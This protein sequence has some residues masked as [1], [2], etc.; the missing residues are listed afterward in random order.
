MKRITNGG[1]AFI[2]LFAVFVGMTMNPNT[3]AASRSQPPKSAEAA[4]L[5][6]PD[7]GDKLFVRIGDEEE[8]IH[9][10]GVDAPEVS[11]WECLA[12]E[13]G[14]RVIELAPTDTE[15]YIERGQTER[16]KGGRLYAYI[17]IPL[18][19]RWE[20]L[21]QV[22]LR[23]GLAGYDEP[24]AGNTKYDKELKK[25]AGAAKKAKDGYF[26]A[27]GSKL[28]NDDKKYRCLPVSDE[29]VA[30]I[31]ALSYD[32]AWAGDLLRGARAV[33][34]PSYVHAYAVAADIEGPGMEGNDQVAVWFV[35]G[36]V[37]SADY[38]LQ[39]RGTQGFA[40]QYTPSIDAFGYV[41][42][43]DFKG[44]EEARGCVQDA[45]K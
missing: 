19:G 10:I 7:D 37:D 20:L 11:K 17:W 45:T 27:C 12:F 21:N 1:F 14:D 31:E 44:W 9:L 16:D 18:N 22:L 34:S 3:A 38:I 43:V 35:P 6:A 39:I 13:A 5:S 24:A 26:S 4:L 25:A 42:T 23:E 33:R 41:D 40:E 32:S 2:L 29:L 36:T 8:H 28:H 30:A 15:V